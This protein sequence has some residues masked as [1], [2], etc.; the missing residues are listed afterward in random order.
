MLATVRR[1]SL[2]VMVCQTFILKVAESQDEMQDCQF[3]DTLA[4][5]FTSRQFFFL[6]TVLCPRY[7]KFCC[8]A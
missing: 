7:G 1:K 4:Y 3:F 8:I 2:F 6:Y 5:G